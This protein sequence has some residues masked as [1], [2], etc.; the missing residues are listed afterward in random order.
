M[1]F[2]SGESGNP[3]GRPRGIQ[4]R[5]VRLRQLVGAQAEALVNKAVDLALSGDTTALKL[6]LERIC[7]P[8][9]SRDEPVKLELPKEGTLTELGYA[10]IGAMAESQLTPAECSAVLQALAGQAKLVELDE[11]EKR[12]A[13]LESKAGD[14]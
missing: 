2:Q 1:P 11:L 4:D 8:I 7:P 13:A 12:V 6:C 10:V 9:K 5:R 3:K 14:R